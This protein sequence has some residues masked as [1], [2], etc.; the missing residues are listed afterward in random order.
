MEPDIFV[1]REEPGQLGADDANDVAKH[2]DE[3][4]AAIKG[5]YKA[6]SARS[7]N[8]KPEGVK[9]GQSGVGLLAPPSVAEEKE[10]KAI[11]NNVEG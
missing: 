5:Q 11:E 8:R 2:G 3:D 4:E 7:P 6:R 10:V 9:A 1:G